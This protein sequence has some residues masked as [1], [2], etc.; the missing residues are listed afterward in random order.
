MNKLS[1][2]GIKP[3]AII[4]LKIPPTLRLV[5]VA[6]VPEILFTIT[7]FSEDMFVNVAFVKVAFEVEKFVP[8]AFVN[9]RLV[10]IA[11]IEFKILAV[12]LPTF[13]APETFKEVRIASLVIFEPGLLNCAAPEKEYVG[14]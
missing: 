2:N 10:K 9:V 11:E 14:I 7:T 4:A 13:E 3:D 6:F 5:K 12:R 8:E 1:N